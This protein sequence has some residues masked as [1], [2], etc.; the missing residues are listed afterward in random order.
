MRL[1]ALMLPLL[2]LGLTV[3]QDGTA[4]FTVLYV[5]NRAG[6]LNPCG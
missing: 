4:P 3:A 1:P 2:A 6:E 5:N